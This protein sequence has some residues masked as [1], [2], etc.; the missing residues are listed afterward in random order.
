V[1]A[2]P[3]APL[4]PAPLAGDG[5]EGLPQI[6]IYSN[7][8]NKRGTLKHVCRD[9]SFPKIQVALTGLIGPI[10]WVWGPAGMLGLPPFFTTL[11]V[12]AISVGWLLLHMLLGVCKALTCLY[13][14]VDDVKPQALCLHSSSG[15]CCM[16]YS[17]VGEMSQ[18][19]VDSPS[20][21]SHPPGRAC[22]WL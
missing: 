10:F 18:G 1:P 14:L 9:P 4:T 20:Y 2:G 21:M 11:V 19:A 13:G 5:A 15:H 3:S 16:A 6:L 7:T 12:Q 22:S 17:A 8:S